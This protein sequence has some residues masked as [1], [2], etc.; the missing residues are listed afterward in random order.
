MSHAGPTA[1]Y[2]GPLKTTLQLRQCSYWREMKRDVADWYRQCDECAPKGKGPPLRPHGHL[3]K[4]Q[5]GVPLDLVT[6]DILSGLPTATNGSKYV[7]VVVDAFTKLIE[8]I[9]LLCLIV[10]LRGH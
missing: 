4:I 9:K 7:L 2:L 5:V 8:T 1:A 3:Q 10:P 6:M